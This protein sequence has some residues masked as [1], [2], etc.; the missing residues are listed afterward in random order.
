[1]TAL[2][3]QNG[4]QELE[5]IFTLFRNSKLALSAVPGSLEELSAKIAHCRDLKEQVYICI[6]ICIY[7]YIY[8]YIYIYICIYIYMYIYVYLY[9]YIYIYV[10][11]YVYS[12]KIAH[13]RDLK[14]QVDLRMDDIY[15]YIYIYT[16]IYMYIYVFT[17]V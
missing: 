16:Y 10:Y 17:Y 11:I 7:M 12:A 15:V 9:I 6:Y 4:A 8:I 2:L 13:Y 1:L 3:N 14:E 5:D